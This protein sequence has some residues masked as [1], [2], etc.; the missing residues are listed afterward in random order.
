M[1][2]ETNHSPTKVTGDTLS[3]VDL[4]SLAKRFLSPNSTLKML[5][6]SEPDK[7][8][9]NEGIAKLEIF[10]KLLYQELGYG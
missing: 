8:T 3:L 7:V 1:M 9:R 6:L 2:L 5:I 10:L 4:K